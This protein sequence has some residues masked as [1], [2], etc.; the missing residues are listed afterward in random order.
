[1]VDDMRFRGLFKRVWELDGKS[2]AFF[3]STSVGTSTTVD[4]FDELTRLRELHARQENSKKFG[5]STLEIDNSVEGTGEGGADSKR[6]P[7]QDVEDA[8]FNTGKAD[9]TKIEEAEEDDDADDQDYEPSKDSD[10]DDSDDSDR[11]GDLKM[12]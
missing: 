3:W 2:T 7:D 4:V 6:D 11:D 5:D 9:L 12:K 10:D 1:M 8:G